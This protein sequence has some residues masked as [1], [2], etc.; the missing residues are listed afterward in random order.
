MELVLAAALHNG[1]GLAFDE[2]TPG[3][4]AA[5]G[6]NSIAYGCLDQYCQVAACGNLQHDAPYG[7][8]QNVFGLVL[9]RQPF[10]GFGRSEEHTS[11]IQSLM[12]NSYAVLC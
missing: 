2:F 7:D 4:D 6:K 8:A 11:K 10:K 9:N 5:Q 12:R 3:V 1:Q